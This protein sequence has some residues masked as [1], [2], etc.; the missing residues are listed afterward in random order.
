MHLTPIAA[1][2]PLKM[3]QLPPVAALFISVRRPGV[4]CYLR[5]LRNANWKLLKFG[6]AMR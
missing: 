1:F 6:D 3:L 4:I 2:T 5:W